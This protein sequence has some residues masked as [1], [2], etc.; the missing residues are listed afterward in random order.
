LVPEYATTCKTLPLSHEIDRALEHAW[1]YAN[2]PNGDPTLFVT[3][4][5]SRLGWYYVVCTDHAGWVFE[6]TRDFKDFAD[7]AAILTRINMR[8]EDSANENIYTARAA[9]YEKW[10]DAL[11]AAESKKSWLRRI[12]QNFFAPD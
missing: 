2:Q 9:K 11:Y 4:A 5:K 10:R 3:E 1:E 8:I 7:V 6:K 12:W